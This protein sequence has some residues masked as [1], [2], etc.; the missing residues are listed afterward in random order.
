MLL[1]IAGFELRQ[2]LRS[3]AFAVAAV[4]SALLVFGSVTMPQIRIGPAFAGGKGSPGA[5]VQVLAIWSLFHLFTAMAFTT[6]AVLRDDQTRFGAVLRSTG[7]GR[8]DYLAGR[9][10]G[11]WLAVCLCFLSVPAG[12]WL[13]GLRGAAAAG[14]GAASAY[15]VG[16]GVV[17]LP[18]LFF[19]SALFFA[20]ATI[21]RSAMAA[22]LGAVALLMLY[23]LGGGLDFRSAAT[24]WTALTEPFGFAAAAPALGAGRVPG[25][26]P[27]L[28]ANRLIWIGVGAL[29]LAFA[30]ARFRFEAP[31]TRRAR[32]P[33]LGD[34]APPTRVSSPARA[35]VRPSLAAQILA[36]TRLEVS[37]V[38]RSPV[39]AV[40][41][42][43]GAFNTAAA[44]WRLPRL[45]TPSVIAQL[46]EAFRLVP[47]V[48]GLVFAGELMWSEREHRMHELIAAAPVPAAALLQPKVL[49][50][51]LVLVGLLLTT[52]AAGAAVQA[53]RGAGSSIDPGAYVR[54]YLLPRA[55]DWILPAVLAVFLQAVAPNKLAGWGYMVLYLV[56]SLALESLGLT[57]GLYRFGGHLDGPLADTVGPGA[58]A[59][60]RW[61]R[62]YWGRLPCSC[63]SAPTCCG[64]EA[65]T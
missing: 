1:A 46:I 35:A 63:W 37:Q 2:H 57:S 22:Y 43:L 58:V 38:A 65:W 55:Y 6:D 41:L 64:V 26:T 11:A 49:A 48:V 56:G 52:A 8:R 12:L 16:L 39:F 24:P 30:V 51:I 34:A 36:R 31:A 59:D 14:H 15:L 10:L 4:L 18:N 9:F 3:P 7:V 45:D 40:L 27:V 5:V 13:A 62:L 28:A 23:G 50:L 53:L 21:T 61:V 44:L 20:L 19:S 60:E 25:L 54:W 29:G 33:E 42:L 17:A 47:I 32:P